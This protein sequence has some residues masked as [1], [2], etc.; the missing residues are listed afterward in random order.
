[1]EENVCPGRVISPRTGKKAKR[2]GEY[3][4]ERA[5]E[6]RRDFARTFD[7]EALVCYTVGFSL[8]QGA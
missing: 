2:D 5:N 3:Y 8:K 6:K 7:L 4:N 1:M